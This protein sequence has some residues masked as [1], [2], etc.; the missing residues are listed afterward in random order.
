MDLDQEV[1]QSLA[2]EVEDLD[3]E[4]LREELKRQIAADAKRKARQQE[5]NKSPEAQE[6]RKA[7]YEKTKEQRAA[8]RKR[9]NAKKKLMLQRAKELGIDKEV[10]AEVEQAT[11]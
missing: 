1:L 8:Y 10:A 6:R 3:V 4:D 11:A 5:Y 7:Y 2:Q 9:Y